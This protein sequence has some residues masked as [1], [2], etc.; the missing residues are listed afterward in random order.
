[1]YLGIDLGD[2]RCGIAVFV[3]KIVI[4]KEIVPR[5]ELVNILKKYIKDYDIK[6]IVVG[7]PF[8][9]YGLDKK[10]LEKTQKFI[11]KLKN[12]F[13]DVEIDSIDERFTTFEAE[14]TLN[15]L[16]EKDTIGKKDAISAGLIL[17]SYLMQKNIF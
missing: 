4:P 13:P 17:E 1:M 15:L 5:V 12:I 9:L 16:G 6:V 11:G 14:N 3:E 10:Q 8:D 2:K 7:L